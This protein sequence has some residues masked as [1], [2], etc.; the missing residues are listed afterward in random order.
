[1]NIYLDNASTTF[2]KP[3]VVSDSIY[4]FLV[5][6]GRGNPGRS[7]HDNGMESNRLLFEARETIAVFLIL[8]T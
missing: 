7:N 5:N 8:V 2:P 1:M 3:K 4:N 6:I